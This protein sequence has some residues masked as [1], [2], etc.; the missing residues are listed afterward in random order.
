M[1]D[2]KALI[3]IVRMDDTGKF[4]Q[5]LDMSPEEFE[6][7]VSTYGK[8]EGSMLH[9][10]PYEERLKQMQEDT[11]LTD[12]LELAICAGA[13]TDCLQQALAIVGSWLKELLD[14]TLKYKKC[15]A[16]LEYDAELRKSNF[17]IYKPKECG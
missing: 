17:S 2:D 14:T 11:G 13:D 7:I 8:S 10:V 15:R 1:P 3:K 16:V 4:S 12:E 6:K 9:S 5:Y